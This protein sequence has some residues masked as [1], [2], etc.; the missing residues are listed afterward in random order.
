MTAVRGITATVLAGFVVFG[1]PTKAGAQTNKRIS[2]QGSALYADLFGSAFNSVLSGVGGELQLRYTPGA[3]SFGAGIQRT[4]HGI[5]GGGNEYL[6][7]I[8]VEPRYVLALLPQDWL[9]P[10]VSARVSLLQEKL[11]D[12]GFTSTATGLT[13]NLG[14]GVLVRLTRRINGEAGASFGYTNF[15]DYRQRQPS[16]QIVVKPHGSGSNL[17]LRAGLAVGLFR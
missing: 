17:V 6:Q 16:G 3:L 9:A 12:Q 1:A 4:R 8:F 13:A 2:I 14:G 7:G 5:V 15:G 11:S 10:Y